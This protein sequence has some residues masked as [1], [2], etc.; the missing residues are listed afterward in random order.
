MRHAASDFNVLSKMLKLQLTAQ[1]LGEDEQESLLIHEYTDLKKYPFMIDA[2][3]DQDKGIQ[4]I[5]AQQSLAN[6][7]NFVKVLVS[8]HRRTI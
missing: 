1:G 6:M 5:V 7:F 3:V 8:P 2:Q 4:E